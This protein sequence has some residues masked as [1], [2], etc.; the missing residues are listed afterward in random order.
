MRPSVTE[1]LQRLLA[2]LAWLAAHGPADL[3]ALAA[4]FD[5]SSRQL[6][7]DLELA[8]LCE[9]PGAPD[10]M[11]DVLIDDDRQVSVNPPRY[12]RRQPRL[13]RQEGFAVLTTGRAALGLDPTLA[14]LE[15]A[16]AKLA[17]VLG[18]DADLDIDLDPPEHLV[19]FRHAADHGER[20]RVTYWSDWRDE[21]SERSL[22]PLNV[23][24]LDG[25]WYTLALDHASGQLR[26][27]RLDRVR[28]A[29]ATGETFARP[30]LDGPVA[31]FE[32]PD[33]AV[34][35]RVWFPD[36][37]RWVADYVALTVLADPAPAPAEVATG[38][39]GTPEAPGA[40]PAT[41]WTAELTVVGTSF[42]ARL[43]VRTR[44]HV[45]EPVEWR[46]LTARTAA[47][48]LARYRHP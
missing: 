33:Q 43:L 17:A 38:P 39:P 14:D 34:T 36:D 3:D 21:E 15:S 45:L 22:D 32:A 9:L 30:A 12:L 20:L 11:I 1:R 46:G 47:E 29:R 5:V 6:E 25:A 7:A 24:F 23:Y 40:S 35:V 42:L 37:A 41:G 18:I 4:R 2:V 8:N 19:L 10:Q 44:G 48:V 27:F 13:S 31:L 16:M 28:A 26:R